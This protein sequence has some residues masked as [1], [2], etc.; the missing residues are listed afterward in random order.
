MNILQHEGDKSFGC[1][2][3]IQRLVILKGRADVPCTICI[4]FD[5]FDVAHALAFI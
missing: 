5:D 2:E 1:T 4:L 3:I